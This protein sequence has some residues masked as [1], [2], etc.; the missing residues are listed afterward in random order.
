MFVLAKYQPSYLARSQAGSSSRYEEFAR[1]QQARKAASMY[2]SHQQASRGVQNAG[3][4][5]TPFRDEAQRGA[6]PS[7]RTGPEH[8]ATQPRLPANHSGFGSPTPFNSRMK[9]SS[10]E[11]GG[12]MAG[13][14]PPFQQHPFQ[15]GNL[16]RYLLTSLFVSS[17]SSTLRLLLFQETALWK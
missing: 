7:D 13:K 15:A 8:H 2:A 6:Q 1:M 16:P 14:K 4:R 12:A 3:A 5:T 17:N 9:H 11:N 10:A